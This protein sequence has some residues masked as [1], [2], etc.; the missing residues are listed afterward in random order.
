MNRRQALQQVSLLLGC[1]MIGSQAFLDSACTRSTTHEILNS[2]QIFLL[3]EFG[4]T[5]FP[6]TD[7]PGARAADV[8]SF[9]DVIVA[10]CYTPEDQKEF[11]NGLEKL[12][13][14][15]KK[16]LGNDFL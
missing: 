5:I 6:E 4:E 12:Q 7:T 13:D 15:A 16:S 8:G 10:D 3:D 14:A 2:Y 11:L 9:M 1:T